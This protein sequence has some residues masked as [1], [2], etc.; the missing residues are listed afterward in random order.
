M[1]KVLTG[2]WEVS[3]FI[4]IYMG[5]KAY[6]GYP[7]LVTDWGLTA[8]WLVVLFSGLLSIVFWIFIVKVLVRFPGKPLTEIT[9]LTFG[10]FFGLGINIIVFFYLLFSTGI[11]LRLFSEASTLTVLTETPVN[12]I[13]LLYLLAAWLA[14]YYGIEAIFRCAIFSLPLLSIGIALVLLLLY[15]YFDLKMLLPLAGSGVGPVLMSSVWGT[16]AFGE[17]VLLAYLV[18]F[19]SFQPQ[20]LKNVGVFSISYIMLFFLAIVI[21]YE[22][23]LPYPTSSETLVPFYQLSRS[24]FLGHYLQRVEAFFVL[25]WAFTA[26]LH[27]AAGL[28]S[29]AIILQDTFKLPFY[30]P[31]L[32][33]LSLLSFT[34]AFTPDNLIEAVKLEGEIRM[35]YGWL[36]TFVLPLLIGLVALILRK[37]DRKVNDPQN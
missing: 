20:K 7:R 13:A 2:P 1:K 15:P 6:L 31:L 34:I 11:V 25:F 22:M 9:E 21:V 23:V 8:G 19:F 32:P 30:R 33:A 18:R 4:I 5:A 26:F 27:I 28:L 12:I 24:I 17:V 29:G 3:A 14:A 16:S 37:G 10:S 36:I 35:V